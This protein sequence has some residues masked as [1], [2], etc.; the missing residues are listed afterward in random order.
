MKYRPKKHSHL[1]VEFHFEDLLQVLIGAAVLAIP[2]GFTAEVWRLGV[3]LPGFNVFL[4]GIVSVLFISAFT[5]HHYYHKKIKTHWPDFT[6][7]V[8]FT[9]VISFLVV[10]VLL[11][12]IQQ[13]P[14]V[15][16]F[17]LALK[18]TVIVTLPSTMSAAI[19]DVLK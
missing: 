14:W 11:T 13:T 2:V 3:N 9:Y 5:Y 4:I 6:E 12:L 17:S 7:R 10:A 8:L 16:D 18:R 15:S 19:A 1:R